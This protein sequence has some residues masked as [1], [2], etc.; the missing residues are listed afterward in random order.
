MA[1]RHIAPQGQGAKK[2]PAIFNQHAGSSIMQQKIG[3]ASIVTLI[4]M[5]FVLAAW[6]GSAPAASETAAL[7]TVTTQGSLA[8]ER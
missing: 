8:A 4:A 6:G 1:G 3:F 5:L 2:R 7:G